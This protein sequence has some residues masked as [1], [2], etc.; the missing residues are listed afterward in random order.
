MGVKMLARYSWLRIRSIVGCYEYNNE[1]MGCIKIRKHIESL[2]KVTCFDKTLISKKTKWCT[3]RHS[4]QTIYQ[5]I[6]TFKMSYTFM[7]YA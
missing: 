7:V 5:G 4:T 2:S 1:H 3:P 6:F